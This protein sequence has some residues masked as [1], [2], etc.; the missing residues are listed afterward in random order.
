[1]QDMYDDTNSPAG[2]KPLS[3]KYSQGIFIMTAIEKYRKYVSNPYR[4]STVREYN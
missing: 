3:Y 4:T 2:F 1:M